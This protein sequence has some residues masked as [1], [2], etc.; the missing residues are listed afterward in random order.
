MSRGYGFIII[1]GVPGEHC[2]GALAENGLRVRRWQVHGAESP[3][4]QD[5]DSRR[6]WGIRCTR[7][8]HPPRAGGNLDRSIERDSA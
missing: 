1:G 7:C 6:A 8:A 2:V 5:H 3:P 4:W